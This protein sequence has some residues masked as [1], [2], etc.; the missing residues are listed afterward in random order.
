[1]IR[2][3]LR[4]GRD[5]TYSRY[6]SVRSLVK[7]WKVSVAFGKMVRADGVVVFRVKVVVELG[8]RVLLRM[9][10]TGTMLVDESHSLCGIECQ[11]RAYGRA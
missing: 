1:M 2:L 4:L 8:K 10:E 7:L 11:F 9:M 3:L 5:C 6:G